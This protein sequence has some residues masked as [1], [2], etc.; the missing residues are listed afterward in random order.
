M[1]IQSAIILTDCSLLSVVF[2][3]CNFLIGWLLLF[4]FSTVSQLV[5]C[6]IYTH[7]LALLNMCVVIFVT[8]LYTAAI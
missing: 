1:S 8:C 6:A 5:A 7:T 4:C 3:A 2:I